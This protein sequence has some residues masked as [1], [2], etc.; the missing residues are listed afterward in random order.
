M[1]FF[2][3]VLALQRYRVRGGLNKSLKTEDTIK[4]LL[5]E[6]AYETCLGPISSRYHLW[7]SNVLSCSKSIHHELS[8]KADG[9]IWWVS[10]LDISERVYSKTQIAAIESVFCALKKKGCIHLE[11]DINVT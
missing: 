7:E 2:F 6:P 3:S 5:K 9:N 8:K 1:L 4:E 10:R 11:L